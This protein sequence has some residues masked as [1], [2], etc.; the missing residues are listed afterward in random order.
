VPLADGQRLRVGR[1]L[2]EFRLGAIPAP[3]AGPAETGGTRVFG[4]ER[5]VATAALVEL[6]AD[7]REGDR[8]LL[9]RGITRIGR[10]QDQDL[11]LGGDPT[12][13]RAQ[14]QIRIADDGTVGVMD[15]GT[16]TKGSSGGTFLEIRAPV[17][18]GP[19]AC[20]L[21]GDRVFRVDG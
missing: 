11:P 19:G 4:S 13:S 2:F 17:E 20:F 3:V 1:L 18:L 12:V 14:I 9:R 10:G 8:R 5:E 16:E 15:G 6:V 21:A 7:G